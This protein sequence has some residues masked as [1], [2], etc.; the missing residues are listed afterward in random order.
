M[1]QRQIKTETDKLAKK[2]SDPCVAYRLVTKSNISQQLMCVFSAIS[3]I[4]AFHDKMYMYIH[5]GCTK[6]EVRDEMA[7]LSRLVR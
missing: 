3:C 7:L 6:S 5:T 4:D 2:Q 1:S